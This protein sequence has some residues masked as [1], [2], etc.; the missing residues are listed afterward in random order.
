MTR[1]SAWLPV[2]LTAVLLAGAVVSCGPRGESADRA[3]TVDE[4]LAADRA[5]AEAV[6]RDGLGG[7][8]RWFED[9]GAQ[10]AAGEVYR[11]RREIEALMSPLFASEDTRFVWEPEG[12]DVAASGDLGYTWGRYEGS[13]T[14]QN[15]VAWRT[16][17][18]YVTVWRRQDDGSWR[19]AID[20]GNEPCE[21]P[22]D[23]SVPEPA[24]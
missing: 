20:I 18:R 22:V 10:I 11:G 8:L 5:F 14:D 1:R 15:G 3:A 21:V 6:A 4:L 12:G 9:D 7:W 13:G 23:A 2:A 16:A 19:V 17:G 24:P